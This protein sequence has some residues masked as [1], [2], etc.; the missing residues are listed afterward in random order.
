[1]EVAVVLICLVSLGEWLWIAFMRGELSYARALEKEQ[2]RRIKDLYEQN[3]ELESRESANERLIERFDR[4]R[5]E[6]ADRMVA[7]ECA[8][9]MNRPFKWEAPPDA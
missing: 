5:R 7:I 2:S 9:N 8:T 3:S 1:M 6:L 4:E